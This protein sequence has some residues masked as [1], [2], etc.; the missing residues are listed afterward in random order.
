MRSGDESLCESDAGDTNI[1]NFFNGQVARRDRSNLDAL[2]HRRRHGA[3]T[4]D[5]HYFGF[6]NKITFGVSY[7]HGW[8]AFSANEELG[9]IQ[10]N[11]VVGGF[12]YIVEEQASGISSV[13]V[14]AAN[15]YLGVYALDSLDVTDRI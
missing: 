1:P 10:P 14:R 13:S 2:A 15:D 6:H 5:D 8:T 12:G 4:N 11:L 3:G 9:I 7:D